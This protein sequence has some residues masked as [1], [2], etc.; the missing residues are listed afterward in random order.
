MRPVEERVKEVQG[1]LRSHFTNI[2]IE[3]LGTWSHRGNV[4]KYFKYRYRNFH[5][6]LGQLTEYFTFK[7]E[8]ALVVLRDLER[9]NPQEFSPL[10]MDILD[11]KEQSNSTI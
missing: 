4:E 9:M 8:N 3:V 2:K 11:G 5:Y 10:E 1:D 6:A 7:D